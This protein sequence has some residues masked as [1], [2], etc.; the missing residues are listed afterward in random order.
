MTQVV[1]FPDGAWA[2]LATVAD[3][4]GMSIAEV[5]VE[6]A[7]HVMAAKDQPKPV[8]PAT[9]RRTHQALDWDEVARLHAQGMNDRQISDVMGRPVRSIYTARTAMKLPKNAEGS[10]RQKSN[11]NPKE[12]R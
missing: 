3:K 10:W 8:I 5:L 1:K 7:Q 6:A 11:T 4:R 2:K 12:S 9:P